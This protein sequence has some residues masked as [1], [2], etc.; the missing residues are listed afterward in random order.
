MELLHIMSIIIFKKDLVYMGTIK[1]SKN[2]MQKNIAMQKAVL[3]FGGV[4][5][6]SEKMNVQQSTISKWL[7]SKLP[8]PIK[9]AVKIEELTNGKIKAK[10]LRPD[11]KWL[12]S[13]N[14]KE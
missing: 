5:K 12:S 8:V 11:L 4:V 3:L 6:L 10:D 14:I 7:H 2:R 13:L 9:H 1:N